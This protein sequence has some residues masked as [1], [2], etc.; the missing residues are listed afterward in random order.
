MIIRL[1]ENDLI[2]IVKKVIKEQNNFLNETTTYAKGE[3]KFP[4]DIRNKMKG[5]GF[6]YGFPNDYYKIGPSDNPKAINADELSLH[7]LEDETQ[8]EGQRST[9]A[10]EMVSYVIYLEPENNIQMNVKNWSVSISL[11]KYD[12]TEKQINTLKSLFSNLKF[13]NNENYR[14]TFTGMLPTDKVIQFDDYLESYQNET[15]GTNQDIS[16]QA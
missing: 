4:G 12:F 10:D 7:R 5:N 3:W 11:A 13:G 16:N 2:R 6:V 14:Y 9:L 8:G 15:G 1:T